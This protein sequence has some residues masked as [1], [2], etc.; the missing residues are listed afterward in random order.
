LPNEF[1][2]SQLSLSNYA[3]VWLDPQTYGVFLNTIIYVVGAVI[4]GTSI[5]VSLAWLTER[6]DMRGK[7]WVYAGVPLTLAMP[8][9]LQAMAYVLLLSPR[10]GFINKALAGLGIGPINIYTLGGM[11]FIEGIRLVPTAFLMLVPL[12]RAMDPMLEE[13]AAMSG[14]SPRTIVRKVSLQLMLPGLVAVVIYQTMTALEVFEIPAILGMPGQIYVFSTKIYSILHGTSV[15]P[16]YGQANALAIVYLLLAGIATWF[17]MRV[18]GRSERYSIVTGKAYR[19]RMTTLGRGRWIAGLL[20]VAFLLSSLILPFLA[21]LY[22]SFL[23]Y[24]QVPSAAAF[25]AMSLVNYAGIFDEPLLGT[26]IGNTLSLVAIT[27]TLTVLASFA[28]S[29]V[30]VRSKFW[31]R[32]LLDQMAFMPHAIP[33]IVLGLAFFWLFLQGNKIG[34]EFHG[35]V[36][37]MSVA[38]TVSFIAYGSRAM[39]ASMLQIHKDLEEA[40][41]VSGAPRSRI[42]WR[43]FFPLMLPTFAG[44]WIWSMLHA[45]RQAG[46]P[47]MLYQGEDNEVLSILIWNLWSDGRIQEVCAIGVLLIVTLLAMAV[48][49]R[50]LGFGRGAH[51]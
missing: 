25:R 16:S 31:G 50:L 12:F 35:G 46:M 17:Y 38:F 37:A 27:S 47:L 36:L 19:S 43:I 29:L 30:V 41:S 20:V 9:M 32:H 33:G 8:G 48:G 4:I 28:I 2:L 40:A 42:L 49:I 1:D 44:V 3:T 24:L 14:A 51:V 11:I 45:V 13:A 5:A 39:N 18:I 23:P 22:V 21:L 10:V 26:V 6:T 34:L 7:F 15:I